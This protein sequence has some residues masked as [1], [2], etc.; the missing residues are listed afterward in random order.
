V[1]LSSEKE[2]GR[3]T[4]RCEKRTEILRRRRRRRRRY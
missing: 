4:T 2:R 3:L 1:F